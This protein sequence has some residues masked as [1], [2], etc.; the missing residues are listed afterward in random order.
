MGLVS[1]I[2]EDLSDN[3]VG[4]LND[5]RNTEFK[6]EIFVPIKDFWDVILERYE[7]LSESSRCFGTCPS[8]DVEIRIRHGQR[9]VKSVSSKEN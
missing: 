4:K 9:G 6:L 7:T 8:D 1:M 3:I 5:G 2:V